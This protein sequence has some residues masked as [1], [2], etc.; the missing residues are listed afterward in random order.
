[1]YIPQS[2]QLKNRAVIE[3]F[4]KQHS[5]AVMVSSD[6]SATHLPL[7]YAA[8][9]GEQGVFYGHMAKTN[10]HWKTL[11]QQ[12]VLLIFSGA[13][14]YISPMWYAHKPAVPTWNYATV[15]CRGEI[16]VLD[17]TATQQTLARMVS[18][19][20]PDLHNDPDRMPE[21]Y[22]A[23]LHKAIVGIKITVTQIEAKEKLGQHQPT[24]NQVGVFQALK[25]SPHKGDQLLADYMVQRGL[26]LGSE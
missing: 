22:V 1:M 17:E 18:F 7:I 11:D 12:S 21:D 3:A 23:K 8:D 10:P 14:A 19:Y 13:H 4:L 9:E 15:H 26:G 25:N 5:F 16:E 20:E 6:L 2:M 24:E